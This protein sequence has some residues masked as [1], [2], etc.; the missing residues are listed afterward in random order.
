MQLKVLVGRLV[1][2]AQRQVGQ[3]DG[4]NATTLTVDGEQNSV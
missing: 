2:D 3:I 1:D 4:Q